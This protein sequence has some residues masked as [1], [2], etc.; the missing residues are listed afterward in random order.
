MPRVR[1]QKGQQG[2]AARHRSLAHRRQL[3]DAQQ[4][5]VE[6][7]LTEALADESGHLE[8]AG[9]GREGAGSGRDVTPRCHLA[10]ALRICSA[11]HRCL[12]ERKPR[13]RTRTS[14]LRYFRM[15]GGGP[16]QPRLAMSRRARC[17]A[18]RAP[19]ADSQGS[20]S[21]SPGAGSTSW[22]PGPRQCAHCRQLLSTRAVAG[23]QR[24]SQD[25]SNSH[26][27]Q[28]DGCPRSIKAD[29]TQTFDCVARNQCLA[30]RLAL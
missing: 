9:A 23:R 16:G 1:L 11:A 25:R 27:K 8:A 15:A 20:S 22:S 7:Q 24:P 3:H 30:V 5:R 28:L 6:A 13:Q 14:S 21:C 17:L 12:R 10:R 19:R 4:L 26:S 29:L 18:G 2:A